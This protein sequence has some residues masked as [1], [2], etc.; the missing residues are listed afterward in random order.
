MELAKRAYD[1]VRT[2]WRHAERGRNVRA[3]R[4]HNPNLRMT[5]EC[6]EWNSIRSIRHHIRII[7]IICVACNKIVDTLVVHALND[8]CLVFRVSTLGVPELTR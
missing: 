5:N 6:N 4:H 3:L 8:A 1:I 7:R 2:A